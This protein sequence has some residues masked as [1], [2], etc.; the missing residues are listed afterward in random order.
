MVQGVRKA[1]RKRNRRSLA[2]H[3]FCIHAGWL[4]ARSGAA[5]PRSPRKEEARSLAPRCAGAGQGAWLSPRALAGARLHRQLISET[6]HSDR[7]A[8]QPR[9]LLC[10]A[11]R[12][13]GS[14]LQASH[15]L[16][17]QPELP[18]GMHAPHSS[19]PPSVFLQPPRRGSHRRYRPL[20]HPC[21]FAGRCH[22]TPGSSA[23]AP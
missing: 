10:R 11:V 14:R 3:L 17:A 15:L 13:A 20:C 21:A 2:P 9:L 6:Q 22:P 4:E 23:S 12:R 19:A 8:A 7:S 5:T 16:A 18:Q 1:A